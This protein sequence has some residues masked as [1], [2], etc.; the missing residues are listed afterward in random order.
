MSSKITFY[1]PV[2]RANELIEGETS[3]L[4]LNILWKVSTVNGC[5]PIYHIKN[6]V[7]LDKT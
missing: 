1:V 3:T 6:K 7:S 4:A 2:N 5:I